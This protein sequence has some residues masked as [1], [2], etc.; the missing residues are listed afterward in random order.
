MQGKKNFYREQKNLG[1]PRRARGTFFMPRGMAK[2][3]ILISAS[4]L[5]RR[6]QKAFLMC[7]SAGVYGEE[8]GE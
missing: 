8:K 5:W 4:F 7:P 3:R 6:A 2:I 1:N